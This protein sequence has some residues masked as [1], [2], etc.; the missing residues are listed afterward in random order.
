MTIDSYLVGRKPLT[1]E[2]DFILGMVKQVGKPIGEHEFHMMMSIDSQVS[3]DNTYQFE[4][5][6]WLDADGNDL[7][8][9]GCLSY[10]E[11]LHDV[12]GSLVSKHYLTRNSENPIVISEDR[13]LRLF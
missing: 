9:Y 1:E 2:E 5:K 8:G 6:P 13:Q 12:I 7:T 11:R 10:S 4:P 3:R